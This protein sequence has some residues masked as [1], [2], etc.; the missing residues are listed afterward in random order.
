LLNF[1]RTK[2]GIGVL[3]VTRETDLA[4][5][6]ERAEFINT[7]PT[8]LIDV[9]TQ[10]ATER[11][12]DPVIYSGHRTYNYSDLV[13]GV[14]KMKSVLTDAGVGAGDRVLLI[15]ENGFTGIGLFYAI[16]ALD[17]WAVLANERISRREVEVMVERAKPRLIVCAA[18]DKPEMHN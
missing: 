18:G 9:L 11:P 16:T 1:L 5:D 13:S 14:E 2:E 4:T 7:L 6:Q 3:V 8:R 10:R 17:A 12:Q 15:M